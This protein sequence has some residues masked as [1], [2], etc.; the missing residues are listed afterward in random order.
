MYSKKKNLKKATTVTTLK[1]TI[2]T[3]KFKK[4]INKKTKKVKA[5]TCYVKVRAYLKVN[6]VRVFGVWSAK[7]SVKIKK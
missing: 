6:G 4:V 3:K 5:T 7:K 1:A 2:K